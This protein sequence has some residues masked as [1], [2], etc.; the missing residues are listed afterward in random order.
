MELQTGSPNSFD[1]LVRWL[2]YLSPKKKRWLA[3]RL[4]REYG[5]PAVEPL[6]KALKD[7]DNNVRKAAAESLGHIGDARAVEPLV[8]ALR[9]IDDGVRKAAA[10]ALSKIG[11]PAVEP[12]CETL[13]SSWRMARVEAAK[14]LGKIGDAR[15][16]P[17]LL[18]ALDD[19]WQ[20]ALRLAAL[21]A[22]GELKDAR[23]VQPLIKRLKDKD[24]EIRKSAAASLGKIQDPQ[25]VSEVTESLCGALSDKSSRVRL[26]AA[27]AL[28]RILKD[29]GDERA[30]E[31]LLKA[32]RSCFVKGSARWHL[33]MGL[34]VTL[35]FLLVLAALVWGSI[36]LNVAAI[37]QGISACLNYIGFYYEHRRTQS[38]ICQQLLEAL[39]NVVERNPAPELRVLL[40]DLKAIS[41]D[42][43]QQGSQTRA[44]SRQAAQKIETLTEQ[45]KNLP[46]PASAPAPDTKTLPRVADAPTP[47][48]KTLPRVE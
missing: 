16:V 36:A 37:I 47:D 13:R 38:K 5:K 1:E 32:I 41:A 43:I 8:G 6:C 4:L 42:V 24:V 30:I 29:S 33:V 45:L 19:D 34:M 2:S 15:A 39:A 12:L 21:Q 22:L 26:A 48:V 17:P 11:T 25:T 44:L 27:E 28:G 7:P 18:D 35:S 23:A 20:A 3:A 10:E 31:P 40:P 9:A 46:L 14:T